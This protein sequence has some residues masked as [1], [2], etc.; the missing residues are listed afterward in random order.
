MAREDSTSVA[1]GERNKWATRGRIPGPA[2][3]A[4]QALARR[5]RQPFPGAA[6]FH[7]D[8]RR[9]AAYPSFGL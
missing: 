6:E 7:L 3:S 4:K 2:A 8:G 1:R 5:A 9:L